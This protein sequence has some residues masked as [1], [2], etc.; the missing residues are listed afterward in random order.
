VW[1]GLEG[2]FGKEGG[3]VSSAYPT[4][5]ANTLRG[6]WGY[7]VKATSEYSN[8]NQ[9]MFTDDWY[10]KGRGGGGE[11]GELI[12]RKSNVR[13]LNTYE[14]VLTVTC[15]IYFSYGNEYIQMGECPF[16]TD[17]TGSEVVFDR[18]SSLLNI[19][20][21]YAHT[22]GIY[23]FSHRL[24]FRL[25]IVVTSFLFAFTFFFSFEK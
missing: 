25:I 17:E 15:L 10:A 9:L 21:N 2:D 19:A 12:E 5:Y 18:T 16:P 4:S 14:E 22:Y 7:T 6:T 13:V 3:N 11:S 1:V 8:G 23:F 20:F 24:F